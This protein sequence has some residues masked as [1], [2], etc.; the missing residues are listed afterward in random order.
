[1]NLTEVLE[2]NA[3]L[4]HALEPFARMAAMIPKNI[5]DVVMTGDVIAEKWCTESLP[6]VE[7]VRNAARVLGMVEHG[8][9]AEM[10]EVTK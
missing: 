3:E 10:P 9:P 5:R 2:E 1:M 7:D 6:S 4:R 8:P